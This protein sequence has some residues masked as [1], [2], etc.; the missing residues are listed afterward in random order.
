MK[1]TISLK[2]NKQFKKIYSKGK[3]FAN[4]LLVIYYMKNNLSVVRLGITVNKKVG[5]AV[6]RNRVRRLIK[7]SYRLKEKYLAEGYD[8]V[9]VS[10]IRAKDA[11]DKEI[12]GAMHHLL[13][14]AGLLKI[15]ES[16]CN[17]K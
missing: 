1:R 4:N 3:S 15:E 5:K 16:E 9:F 17:E 12:S 11:T 6:V 2:D 7:E 10:R 8:I 13:K 14:K